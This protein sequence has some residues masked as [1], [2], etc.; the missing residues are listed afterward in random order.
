[1]AAQITISKACDDISITGESPVWSSRE[2]AL[3]WV[4]V[5][6]NA[7]CRLDSSRQVRRWDLQERISSIGFRKDGGLIG[8]LQS[9]IYKIDISPCEKYAIKNLITNPRV[10]IGTRPK[11]GKADARGYWWFGSTCDENKPLGGYH[12]MSPDGKCVQI[13]GDVTMA[14]GV[15]INASGKRIMAA[16][17]IT[18]TIWTW[19]MDVE[20]NA[21]SDRHVFNDGKNIEGLVDGATF[22]E[23]GFYWCALFGAWSVAKFSPEGELVQKIRVPVQYPTMCA[24]GGEDL[25]TLYVTSSKFHAQ[26]DLTNQPLAGALFKIEGSGSRGIT[27]HEFG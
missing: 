13:S 18:N 25:K 22:D 23:D 16:D 24:F 26:H 11:E 27:E 3:Y 14:N 2:K 8:T 10:P 12:R 7:I 9:G 5:R 15:A 6:S 21:I 20:K 17:S 1:M 19:S 4:D